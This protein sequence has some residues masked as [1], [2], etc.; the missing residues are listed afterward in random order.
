MNPDVQLIRSWRKSPR[1]FIKD[2]WKLVPERDNTKF[3]SGKHITWQQ[4]DILIAV[5]K[6]LAKEAPS[7]IS[8]SSGHGIGKSTVLSWLVLWYL[9]CFKDAQIPCTAP[10]SEQMH[11]VLWKELAK[12]ISR[13]PREIQVKYEWQNGYIRIVESPETWFARAKTARKEAPEALAGVHGDHVMFIVDEASGVPDVIYNTGEGALTSGNVIFIMISN[14][15][16]LIGYFY[17]SHHGD[18]ENWQTLSFSSKDS[19]IVDEKFV[20]RILDKHGENS[21]EYAIRVLGKFPRADSIDAQGYIPLLVQKDLRETIDHDFGKDR[22]MGLDPAGEG[23]NETVWVLRDRFKAKVLAKEA[24]STPLSIA[25][26]TL[27]LM[28]FWK[29]EAENVFVDAFGEG[30]K[31][32]QELAKA[33]KYVQ[34]V[35][36]GDS[37]TDDEYLNLRAEAYWKLREWLVGGGELVAHND[38]KQLLQIRYRR[39]LSDK[40]K[41]MGKLEMKKEGI[42]SPDVADALMLTFTGAVWTKESEARDSSMEALYDR[43]ALI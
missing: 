37:S 28:D 16:R 23:S 4:D 40:I 15:T 41:I 9:F 13:M 32:I 18:K 43:F 6:A 42:E 7:R 38:W 14:P 8:V 20:A 1:A 21:D 34:A 26:K 29:V 30:V 3:V 22:C 10:S 2:I 35:L 5:E 33:R 24:I 11:D 25:Q 36:V 27:T 39:E 31:T 17:D 19:P 12:W